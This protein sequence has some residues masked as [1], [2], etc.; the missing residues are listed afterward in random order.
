MTRGKGRNLDLVKWLFSCRVFR[1]CPARLRNN[2]RAALGFFDGQ[3]DM[4]DNPRVGGLARA[5]EP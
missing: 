5:S 3:T 1:L 2:T 4:G